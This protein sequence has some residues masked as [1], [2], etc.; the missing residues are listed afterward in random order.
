MRN[1]TCL[2]E[3]VTALITLCTVHAR[4]HE[5]AV[6][7]SELSASALESVVTEILRL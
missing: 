4:L 3:M 5:I 7:E 6:V 1:V 2:K